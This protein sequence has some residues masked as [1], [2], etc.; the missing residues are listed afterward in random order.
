[1]NL[2][3]SSSSLST[4]MNTVIFPDTEVNSEVLSAVPAGRHVKQKLLEDIERK[5]GFQP[6]DHPRPDESDFASPEM[7]E[8]SGQF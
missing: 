1:M 5:F 8:F 6:I 2:L 7:A 4:V 3:I